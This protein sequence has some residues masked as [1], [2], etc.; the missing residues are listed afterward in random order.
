VLQARLNLITADPLRLDDSVK[1]IET[2]VRPAVE[3]ELG[4]LGMS[5]YTNPELGVAVLTSFWVSRDALRHSEE[6][7]RPRRREA[8]KRAAGTVSVERYRVPVF[9]RKAPPGTGTALRLTRMD[10][11][12]SRVEDV[13]EVYGDTVVPWFADAEGFCSSLLLVDWDTGHSVSATMW[14]TPQAL[15][16]SRSLAAA[17]RVETVTASECVIRAVEEYGLVFDSSRKA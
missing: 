17:V 16:A 7:A 12:P 15:A 6:V 1:F 3:N 14:R 5:L 11:E 4:S 8:I 9:E 10:V 13:V 2:D